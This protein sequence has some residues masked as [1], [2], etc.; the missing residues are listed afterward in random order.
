MIGIYLGTKLLKQGILLC[1]IKR[2]ILGKRSFQLNKKISTGKNMLK[3]SFI[4]QIILNGLHFW[5][6]ET[7]YHWETDGEKTCLTYILNIFWKEIL[8]LSSNFV[9]ISKLQIIFI[10]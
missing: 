2:Q 9:S 8:I 7:V 10:K 3:A 6:R 4:I 1:L 5:D